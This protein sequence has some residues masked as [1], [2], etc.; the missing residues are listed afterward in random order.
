MGCQKTG[1]S[2]PGVDAAF[3]AETRKLYEWVEQN[4]LM[5]G[6]ESHIQNKVDE[7]LDS[8]ATALFKLDRLA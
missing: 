5:I 7:L 4:R 2:F 3:S 6:T 8:L 1:L